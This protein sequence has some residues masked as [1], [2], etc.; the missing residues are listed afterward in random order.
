[1]ARNDIISKRKKPRKKGDIVDK[2]LAK[3][4]VKV[5]AKRKRD[6]IDKRLS[7]KGK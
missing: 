3:P 6:I 2:R 1:M 7:K 4:K 5:R